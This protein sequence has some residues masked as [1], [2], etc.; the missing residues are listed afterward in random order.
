MPYHS[1]ILVTGSAAYDEIMDFPGK[2]QD[3]IRPDKIHNL[4]ISFAVDKLERQMGGTGTNIA[5]NLKFLSKKKIVLLASV[6]KDGQDLLRFYKLNKIDNSHILKD[7]RL[8]TATGKVITDR[9]DNQI[10]GFYYGACEGGKLLKLNTFNPKKDVLIISA[11]HPA[12]FLEI[13][14]Q[15]IYHKFTYMYDPGMAITWIGKDKLLEGIIN[16]RWL[17]GNDYEIGYIL[18]NT[19]TTITNLIKLGKAVI[20]TLGDKGVI[21]K[22]FKH[23]FRIPAYKLRRVVDPTGAGDAWRG[24]FLSAVLENYNIETSLKLANALASFA[25][26]T[27]GTVNHKPTKREIYK[28]MKSII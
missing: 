16:C 2:F 8:Y 15:A 21:Y 22:D 24:G 11:N 10:W 3:Y 1:S 4:N 9:N 26:E 14:K 19:G 27:Y 20:T 5:Y 18:K 7:D 23:E 17:V 13:Q 25:V 12:A 6:G 28:R